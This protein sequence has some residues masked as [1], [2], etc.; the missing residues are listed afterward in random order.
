MSQDY[1]L[2]KAD[3]KFDVD[4]LTEHQKE[5]F[6]R[7][8][9]DIPALYNDLSQSSS[10]DTQNLQEWFDKR[11]KSFD[12]AERMNK[13]DNVSMKKILNYD[14]N[15]EN[16]IE[17]RKSEV[18]NKSIVQDEMKSTE[19][20]RQ[21]LSLDSRQTAESSG[22]N[23]E[24][25]L[26][27]ELSKTTQNGCDNTEIRTS[28]HNTT[29]EIDLN[30]HEEFSE[31]RNND[32]RLS[33]SIL[34]NGKRRNRSVVRSSTSPK[35]EEIVSSQPGHSN[36]IQSL[37]RT[38]RPKLIQ[39]PVKMVNKQKISESIEA[40]S[41]EERGVKRKL[42][43]D[44]E[45]ESSNQ[46]RRRKTYL[47]ETVSD[48]DSCKSTESDSTSKH[49][50][51]IIE[52][53]NV[54]QRT[55]NEISRLRI[56]MVF[57]SPLSNSR[58]SK[59]CC[60][61]N[62]EPVARKLSP[63]SKAIKVRFGDQKTGDSMKKIQKNND[64][65]LNTAQFASRKGRLSKVKIK[66]DRNNKI[67]KIEETKK[68][69]QSKRNELEEKKR[70]EEENKG[71]DTLMEIIS[72]TM[73]DIKMKSRDTKNANEAKIEVLKG[74]VSYIETKSREI[75]LNEDITKDQHIQSTDE[76]LQSQYDL[77]EIIENSQELSELEKK[78]NEKQCFIKINKIGDLCNV[79]KS[80]EV[81]NED[82]EVAKIVSSNYNNDDDEVLNDNINECTET[83]E[84][85]IDKS[86]HT[87]SVIENCTFDNEKDSFFEVEKMNEG[88]LTK[89]AIGFSSPKSNI[90]RQLRF[91]PYSP[92]GRAAHM[93]GLVTKQAR[94]E[95]EC[96]TIN[97]D[98]D[99]VIR[100]S[101]N[102]DADNEILPGKKE[103]GYALKEVDKVAAS[104]S[105]RQEKIFNNMRSSDYCSSPP[106]KLFSNLKNDG[107]KV[108]L[109]TDKLVDCTSVE[110][111][112]EAEKVTDETSLEMD[113][114][115]MLE[116]SSANP[117]SLTASPSASILKRYRHS[118]PEP[119]PE[120]TT[121][122]KVLHNF[123]YVGV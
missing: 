87:T 24:N 17:E 38:L 84:I 30:C 85:D 64:K 44:S 23:E 5:S 55:R 22:N 63:E 25:S 62:K 14:P 102:K 116:W 119:D 88:L 28:L 41:L 57:D 97:I 68:V 99:S 18:T 7:K 52:D 8:R 50:E 86:K 96:H 27:E 1:V 66:A 104:C 16:K 65:E 100:K 35:S 19:N 90:K 6:K 9:E 54:S 111:D 77:D 58:R 105:S 34:D 115:P 117:P 73:S 15:K 118:I 108:F 20:I 39:T 37:Q 32:Q 112:A 82:A 43:S 36:S 60:E 13:K 101:K 71:E 80:Q 103:R 79:I 95:S 49:L 92:Q 48:S 81:T 76:K 83:N 26:V 12:E 78:C 56:N 106:I 53:G 113:E 94:M 98:D 29:N 40:T 46:R 3:L 31:S 51:G 4:R 109:K 2:I 121:P 67:S 69:S 120:S 47:L 107:E 91:K 59:G 72:N 74:D 61:D 93:L 33:P 122:N 75:D 21:N 11:N 123:K 45:T 42:V 114:L 70:L 110:T 89:S 10:Q